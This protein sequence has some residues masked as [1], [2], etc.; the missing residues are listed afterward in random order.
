MAE[1]FLECPSHW[2]KGTLEPDSKGGLI[3]A[4]D[5]GTTPKTEVERYWDGDIPW[6][7]PKEISRRRGGIFVSKTERTITREGLVESS[8]KLHPAGTVM[9]TK[10]APVGIVAVNTAP[11]TV[12]QGFLAFTC[13]LHLRSTYLAYWLI[14]NR[15]YLEQVAN[16]STYPEIYI[17]DLFEFEISV[18]PVEYQDQVIQVI[19]TLQFTA[20][21]ALPMEQALGDSAQITRIHAYRDRMEDLVQNM[22]VLLL[23][24]KLGVQY[25]G[26]KI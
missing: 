23:S 26:S 5:T 25:V 20:M 14:A 18:P 15:P 22:L 1:P 3:V 10:R 4:A 19:K 17:T 8:L 13:G 6:L 11:M 2:R 21:L 12:N 16:G 7:T 24:G 9:L